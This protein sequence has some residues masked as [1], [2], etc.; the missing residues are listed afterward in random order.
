M[1]TEAVSME[2]S[3]CQRW[4]DGNDGGSLGA[5]PLVPSLPWAFVIR[6]KMELSLKV[7]SCSRQVASVETR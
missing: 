6:C 3:E 2:A 1:D 5:V 7:T 4:E